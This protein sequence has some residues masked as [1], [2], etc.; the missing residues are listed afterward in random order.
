MDIGFNWGVMWVVFGVLLGGW[1]WILGGVAIGEF[2][3]RKATSDGAV[4]AL[5]S[6]YVI[7]S[8]AVLAG[9]VTGGA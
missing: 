1:L 6:A 8:V 2:V 4:I 3:W 9:F 5:M 7:L